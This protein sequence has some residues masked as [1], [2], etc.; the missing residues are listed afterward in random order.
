MRI[1]KV[2]VGDLPDFVNSSEYLS[3]NVKPITPLRAVSQSKNPD[4][5][6]SDTALVYACENNSLLCFAGLLPASLN[7]NNGYAASN[8]GWWVNQGMGK[9]LGLPLFMRAFNDCNRRMFFTDCS[10]YTK[11]IGRAHV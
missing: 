9:S 4:A 1:V 8:S 2:T 7:H 5:S 6:A 3:L 11:E 10:A